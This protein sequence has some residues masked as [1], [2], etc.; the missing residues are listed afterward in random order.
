MNAIK[1]TAVESFIESV[2]TVEELTVEEITLHPVDSR[3]DITDWFETEQESAELDF[4]EAKMNNGNRRFSAYDDSLS[5][6]V[7]DMVDQH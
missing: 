1:H 2:T 4:L 6:D 7:F 3:D 5:S